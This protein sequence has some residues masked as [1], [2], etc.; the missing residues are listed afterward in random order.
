MLTYEF[1]GK[2]I[3]YF[4]FE[5]LLSIIVNEKQVIAYMTGLN[6]KY[7]PK[8]QYRG[9]F[10]GSILNAGV[11]VWSMND[12]PGQLPVLLFIGLKAGNQLKI[13]E[14]WGINILGNN[15]LLSVYKGSESFGWSAGAGVNYTF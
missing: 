4:T 11:G 6:L 8:G 15:G 10:I 12:H 14:N 13:N 1:S 9:F 5:L 2:P 7:Y 3:S